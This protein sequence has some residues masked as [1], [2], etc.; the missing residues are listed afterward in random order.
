MSAFSDLLNA[1]F[2]T[3]CAACAAHS[4]AGLICEQ[5]LA[6]RARRIQAPT[7]LIECRSLGVYAEG[8]GDAV[9]SAKYGR[10][11]YLMDSLGTWLGRSI[12]DWSSMNAELVVS[13][14]VPFGRMLVRGFDHGRRL[15]CG[16]SKVTGVPYVPALTCTDPVRQVGS[17]AA[18]RR[19]LPRT[20]FESRLSLDGKRVLLVDDVVT[21]GTTLS[22]AAQA[23]KRGGAAMVWGLTVAHRGR[24]GNHTSK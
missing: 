18:V 9:R 4:A 16:V 12:A 15:A 8:F 6:L 2:P 10:N 11:L 5:C 22:V 17:S 7:G 21:T 24:K 14:P 1:V 3:R 20:A 19:Q 13:V 23:L